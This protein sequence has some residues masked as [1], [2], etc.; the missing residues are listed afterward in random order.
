MR[1]LLQQLLLGDKPN[2]ELDNHV[3]KISI[4]PIEMLNKLLEKSEGGFL[5]GKHPSLADLQIFFEATN[6]LFCGRNYKEYP[7][8]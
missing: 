8:I 7:H 1:V 3:N 2:E 5:V 4:K 6:E